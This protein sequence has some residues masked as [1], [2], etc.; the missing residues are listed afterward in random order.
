MKVL[1]VLLMVTLSLAG[2]LFA[3]NIDLFYSEVLKQS[4]LSKNSLMS[5]KCYGKSG[6]TMSTRSPDIRLRFIEPPDYDQSPF[7]FYLERPFF[8]IDGIHLSTDE[9]RT[10]SQLHR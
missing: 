7:G 3:R 9:K 8:I 4:C 6:S 10:L 5:K 2:T 1:K